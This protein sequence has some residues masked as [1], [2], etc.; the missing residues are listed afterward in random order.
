MFYG[1]TG[2]ND[3]EGALVLGCEG[4][5]NVQLHSQLCTALG[6]EIYLTHVKKITRAG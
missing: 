1:F 6:V 3:L 4:Q 5:M 2:D